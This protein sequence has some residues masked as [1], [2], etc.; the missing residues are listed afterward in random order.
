MLTTQDNLDV[1]WTD[2]ILA[3]CKFLKVAVYRTNNHNI[4][5][6]DWNETN[7]AQVFVCLTLLVLSLKT[8][9]ILLSNLFEIILFNYQFYVYFR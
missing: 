5:P 6:A 7:E 1:I 4:L 8:D 3:P 9:F 2:S